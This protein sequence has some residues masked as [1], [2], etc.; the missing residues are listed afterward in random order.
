VCV[1]ADDV[2]WFGRLIPV[3]V[4]DMIHLRRTIFTTEMF[5]EERSHQRNSELLSFPFSG[6]EYFRQTNLDLAWQAGRKIIYLLL[7]TLS[8]EEIA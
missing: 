2:Y 3:F 1:S 4:M 8:T 7:F 5:I 6:D